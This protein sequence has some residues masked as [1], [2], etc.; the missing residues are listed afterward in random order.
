MSTFTVKI[1]EVEMEADTPRQAALNTAEVIALLQTITLM[2][3]VDEQGQTHEIDLSVEEID[4]A[5][6]AAAAKRAR[7]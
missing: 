3:V 5:I 1:R 6:A 7:L 2:D 4:M